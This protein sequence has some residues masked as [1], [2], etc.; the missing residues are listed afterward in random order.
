MLKEYT[1]LI[2]DTQHINISLNMW[3]DKPDFVLW[4]NEERCSFTVTFIIIQPRF[5]TGTDPIFY[6]QKKKKK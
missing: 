6:P 5:F 2:N 4:L 3:F 1:F